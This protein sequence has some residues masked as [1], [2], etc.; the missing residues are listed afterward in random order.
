MTS[1]SSLFSHFRLNHFAQTSLCNMRSG[2]RQRGPI[3]RKPGLQQDTC[4]KLGVNFGVR[5]VEKSRK[6]FNKIVGGHR[7]QFPTIKAECLQIRS[8]ISD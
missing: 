3:C 7:F 2:R 8:H 6:I 4:W 1:R 5:Q